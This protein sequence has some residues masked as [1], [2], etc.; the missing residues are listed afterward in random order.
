SVNAL[1][2]NPIRTRV[3]HANVQ[4]ASLDDMV[5]S[6][7]R[8]KALGFAMALS[9]GQH[10]NDKELSYYAQTPSSFEWEVEDSVPALSTPGIADN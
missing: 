9:V 5:T 3:Q 6:Y 10:T 8:V 2:I 4:V 1:P 7:Q